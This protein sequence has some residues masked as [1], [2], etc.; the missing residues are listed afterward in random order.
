[1]PLFKW[2]P[3]MQLSYDHECFAETTAGGKRS[4]QSTRSSD[5]MAGWERTSAASSSFNVSGGAMNSRAR[6]V[7]AVVKAAAS[8]SV[9]STASFVRYWVTPSH[10]PESGVKNRC[11][12]NLSRGIC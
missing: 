11:C 4:T 9:R 7:L 12:Q 10:E 8:R 1:M 3:N 6:V 2:E 5:V